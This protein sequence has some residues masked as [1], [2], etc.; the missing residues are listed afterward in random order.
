MKPQRSPLPLVPSLLLLLA[1]CGGGKRVV[2]GNDLGPAPASMA[3]FPAQNFEG[4]VYAQAEFKDHARFFGT[5]LVER[6]GILPIWLKV[7]L[8]G[9]GQNEAQIFL[10]PDRMNLRLFLPDGTTLAA[11]PAAAAIA[12]APEK[13]RPA[14]SDNAFRG[15]ILSTESTEG[16]VFFQ[17]APAAAYEVQGATVR[18]EQGG[19]VRTMNLTASLVAFDLSLDTGPDTSRPFYV[20]IQ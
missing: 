4:L 1:A 8:R 9:E 20:G 14:I 16:F 12:A 3:G 17:L 10:S 13:R 2:K 5:D 18:H 19:I 7:Q 11:V 6:G 15:D